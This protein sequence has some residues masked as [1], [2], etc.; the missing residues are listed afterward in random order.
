MENKIKYNLKNPW[1]SEGLRR[2]IKTKNK[3]YRKSL[4]IK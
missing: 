3:R 4:S 1:L 2:A